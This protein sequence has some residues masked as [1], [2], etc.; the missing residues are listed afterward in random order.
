[1]NNVGSIDYA[2]S[3]W[4]D[5]NDFCIAR[6]SSEYPRLATNFKSHFDK[7]KPWGMT[8]DPIVFDPKDNPIFQKNE[9]KPGVWYYGGIP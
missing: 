3:D 9:V 7:D 4:V 1:M 5:D 2:N 6:K 8:E